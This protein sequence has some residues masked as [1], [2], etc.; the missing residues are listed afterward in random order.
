MLFQLFHSILKLILSNC[1]LFTYILNPEIPHWL[2]LWS[3]RH[4][5]WLWLQLQHP[6]PLTQGE[7]QSKFVQLLTWLFHKLGFSCFLK[8]V[9]S[10]LHVFLLYVTFITA[11]D[12]VYLVQPFPL[13]F[14][15]VVV[16]DQSAGKTSVLEMIA[17]ARIF[18]RGSGEMM[19]RS[20]VKVSWP[21]PT[22]VLWST[23]FSCQGFL[24]LKTHRTTKELTNKVKVLFIYF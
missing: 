12:Y 15:V 20:P 3:P 6:G 4:L 24:I 14:Q 19:T 9:Q 11:F 16:G 2:V 8:M 17:Q 22:D 18:P 7:E 13:D 1:Y 21:G 5:V 10:L 23:W